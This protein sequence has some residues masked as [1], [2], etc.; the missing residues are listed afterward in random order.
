MNRRE[1]I[2]KATTTTTVAA[3][4]LLNPR[5]SRAFLET[6]MES[7][8][9]GQNIRTEYVE[10]VDGEINKLA[11]GRRIIRA[12]AENADDG[13]R[14]EPT[15]PDVPYATKK[16]RLPFEVTDD[17][18][19]QNIEKRALEE[20]LVRRFGKQLGLDLDDLNVN[21]DT[22]AGAGP[23]QAFLQIDNGLLKLLATGA[24]IH[25]V[26]GS[27]INGGALSKEHLFSGVYAMPDKYDSGNL[28][29]MMNR[30]R[31]ISWVETLTDRA[32]A[33]GDA[34]L[35]GQDGPGRSPLGIGTL[36]VPF[37]PDD[38]IVL[39]DPKNFIRVLFNRVKRYRVTPETDWELATR[40]KFGY[41][42]FVR[43]DFIIEENDAVVDIYGLDPVA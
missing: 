33:A 37:L 31:R 22:A 7:S 30:K 11:T 42:F 41:I 25:R 24:G 10:T 43:Q 26:D 16:I 8:D 3:G 28:K 12:A 23:D 6:A 35:G 27:L 4:G 9:F 5:Q 13:Y 32:T 19:E 29:W 18:Y 21:G 39:A 1:A 17:T 14:A 40:D 15:F 2:A 36:E 38:R 34:A 20:K